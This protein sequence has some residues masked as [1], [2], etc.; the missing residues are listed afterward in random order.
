MEESAARMSPDFALV[1][2][3]ET[4]PA[5][6]DRAAAMQPPRS[7][8]APFGFY[9]PSGDNEDQALDGP[10]GLQHYSATLHLVAAT[11]R[12]L[13]LL[14]AE[15]KQAVLSM[16]GEIYRTPPEDEAVGLKGALLVEYTEME[17]SS[18]DLYEEEV[19]L[20]RRM[21]TVRLDYQTV[22]VTEEGSV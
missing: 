14:S 2:A 18:P 12:Q 22:E 5:L 13:Q 8:K 15:V 21:Y 17:Q 3:I 6:R 1:S 10:T 11:C 16:R 9:I 20:Y 19:G 4:V 7:A